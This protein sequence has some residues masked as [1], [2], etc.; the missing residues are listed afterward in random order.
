MTRELFAS[1]QRCFVQ[2][3]QELNHVR[4]DLVAMSDIK[5]GMLIPQGWRFDLPE[6]I[7]AHGQWQLMVKIAKQIEKLGYD[8][9]WLFDHFHSFPKETTRSV[10]E[11][12]TSLCALVTQ[13]KKLR[14]GQIVTCNTYRNPAYLAK[15]SSM[16]D[17]ISNGR[18]EFGLG[19]GWYQKE[20]EAYGYEY[21]RS[22]IRLKMMEETAIIIK[23]MWTEKRATFKGRY[24]K[25]KDAINEPK[26]IQKP[27]K[28]LI[29]GGGE[30]VTLKIVAKHADRLNFSDEWGIKNNERKL[31]LVEKY[32]QQ[33]K[34]D[35]AEIERTLVAT[36][37]INE[38]EDRIDE[39]LAESMSESMTLE[40]Y[41]SKFMI[42][43]SEQLKKQLEEYIKLGFT[44]FIV[45][46][47]NSAEM[48]PQQEFYK[49]VAKA[50]K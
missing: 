46:F 38:E 9:G 17:V 1:R 37:F 20:Y 49:D 13:T 32:A 42:G 34:R 12:Y 29:G 45:F 33:M 16:L 8:S 28:L 22:Y 27:P 26:P 6:N 40:E 39:M 10:F 31:Q 48:R 36:V 14:L 43:T 3:A 24:Y 23:K 47:Q 50:L 7:G 2:S 15:I 35:S 11:C 5:F 41:K 21:Q 4:S 44:T 18:M 25:V 19:A 30:Q